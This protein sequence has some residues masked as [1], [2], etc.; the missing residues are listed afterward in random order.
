MDFLEVM[1]L[2]TF[3]LNDIFIEHLRGYGKL[4]TTKI[5]G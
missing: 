5:V 4:A 1:C 3:E 2:E